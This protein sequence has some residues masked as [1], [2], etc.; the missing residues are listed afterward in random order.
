M[1]NRLRQM[2]FP[3]KKEKQALCDRM[4]KIVKDLYDKHGKCCA[5]CKHTVYM[6]ESPYY[7]YVTCEFD[8]SLEF[9]LGKGTENHCCKK[10]EFASFEVKGEKE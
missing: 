8:R 6:Q 9:G 4:N 1:G 2:F 3:T 10:Y 5:T 7:D